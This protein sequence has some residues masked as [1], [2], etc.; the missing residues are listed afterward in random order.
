M[1]LANELEHEAAAGHDIFTERDS[2]VGRTE[3]Q[4]V[5]NPVVGWRAR[6]VNPASLKWGAKWRWTHAHVAKVVRMEWAI[7]NSCRQIAQGGEDTPALRLKLRRQQEHVPG[8]FCKYGEGEW[9]Y[10]RQ[11]LTIVNMA[12]QVADG[13]DREVMRICAWAAEA[14]VRAEEGEV[15]HRKHNKEGWEAFAK[16]TVKNGAKAAHS[17]M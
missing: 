10:W 17:W 15:Q 7:R 13:V 5:T 11:W 9:N 3:I 8:F 1:E 14:V 16:L 12:E 4:K 2:H 6:E